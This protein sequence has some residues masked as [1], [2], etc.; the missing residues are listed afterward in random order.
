MKEHLCQAISGLRE[1][2]I[3]DSTERYLF[4][5]VK[6]GAFAAERSKLVIDI[7]VPQKEIIMMR[8]TC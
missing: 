2:G 4:K 1:F 6:K 3:S 5:S 7:S 8:T